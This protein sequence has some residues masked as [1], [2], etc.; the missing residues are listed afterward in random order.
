MK[1]KLTTYQQID[2]EG[3][4]Q[5][6][7]VIKVFDGALQSLS[8]AE[9]A[10]AKTDFQSGYT[11]LEKVRRFVVHLYSTLDFVKGG[12]IADQ[13]GKLYVF[14]MNE[15]DI[16]EATKNTAK[17][18]SCAKVLRTLRAGWTGLRPTATSAAPAVSERERDKVD[19]SV[20]VTA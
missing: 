1:K 10:Y 11:E 3:K 9:Q 13:L 14:V 5:L 17:I 16:I 7:L 6:D 15:I 2:T 4:S 19:S 8:A 20:M 18:E 12:E